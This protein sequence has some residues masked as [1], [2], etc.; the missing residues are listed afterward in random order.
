M[1]Q[2]EELMTLI[3]KIKD[4]KDQCFKEFDPEL[5]K[6]VKEARVKRLQISTEI[7]NPGSS[8]LNVTGINGSQMTESDKPIDV[9]YMITINCKY[10]KRIHQLLK[11]LQ[12]LSQRKKELESQYSALKINVTPEK[13]SEQKPPPV[14][15]PVKESPVKKL[16][17]KIAVK[18]VKQVKKAPEVVQE[19]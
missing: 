17:I 9:Y 8:K 16:D 12:A 4:D 13:I 18:P 1:D 15:Q 3:I 2:I 19:V 7:K 6:M 14:K 11:E 5:P 10:K